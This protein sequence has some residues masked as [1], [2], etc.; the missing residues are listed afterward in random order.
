MASTA[1]RGQLRAYFFRRDRGD[2]ADVCQLALLLA[3]HDDEDVERAATADRFD[4]VTQL[5]TG[6]EARR[7][8]RERRVAGHEAP[9]R[10]SVGLFLP[11][12]PAPPGAPAP[13]A[14]LRSTAQLL[15]G[16]NMVITWP[17]RGTQKERPR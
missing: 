8:A 14:P 11:H 13:R 4:V 15:H 6:L 2:R 1:R 5:V 7:L 12:P 17:V 10:D 3:Q 16:K 9:A